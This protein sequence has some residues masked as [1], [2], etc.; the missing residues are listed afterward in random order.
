MDHTFGKASPSKDTM[1]VDTVIRDSFAKTNTGEEE[2]DIQLCSTLPSSE[3]FEED[4]RGDKH[5]DHLTDSTTIKDHNIVAHVHKVPMPRD[6]VVE[7][8]MEEIKKDVATEHII[9]LPMKDHN[10]VAHVHEG[11]MPRD[12]LVETLMEE[13]KRDVATGHAISI[14]MKDHNVVA[15]VSHA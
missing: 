1:N 6:S 9:S 11:P 15:R 5:M 10:V 8:E 12:S 2:G 3:K 4:S 13:I 7:R 14:P